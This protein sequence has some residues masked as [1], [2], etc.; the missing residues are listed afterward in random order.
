ME[1]L[2]GRID[3]YLKNQLSKEE[4][5]KF[6]E[7]MKKDDSLREEVRL[8]QKMIE[9]LEADAWLKT[10]EKIE[11]L[12]RPKRN[13]NIIFLRV[14]AVFIGIVLCSYFILNRQYSDAVLYSDYATPYPDRI[15]T[16]GGVS[17]DVKNAMELYNTQSYKAAAV[18]FEKLRLG[19][20]GNEELFLYEVI[21]LTESEQVTKAILL[22][23]DYSEFSENLIEAFAWQKIMVHLA[24]NDGETARKLLEEYLKK[25]SQYQRQKAE[26]LEEDLN[27]FW[28]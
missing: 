19:R 26:E 4:R 15:T 3:L 14:A 1:E 9:L 10:K 6:E 7:Q 12:N 13:S 20:E 2:T 22:L 8:Q 25:G 11:G 21:A 17:P 18:V 5:S 23:E 24:N 27:S 16:M 28:R